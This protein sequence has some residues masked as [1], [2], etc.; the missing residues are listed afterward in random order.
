MKTLE[1]EFKMMT[2]QLRITNSDED[3]A[4]YLRWI[5]QSDTAR[6]YW[7][8][9]HSCL[10]EFIQTDQNWQKCSHCGLVKPI[11]Q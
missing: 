10:H 1:R 5:I 4:A 2:E 6:D 8:S 3:V 7:I 11:G 9:V